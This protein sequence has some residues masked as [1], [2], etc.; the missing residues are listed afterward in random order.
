MPGSWTRIGLGIVL[1]WMAAVGAA[2]QPHARPLERH[3]GSGDSCYERVYSSEHLE[4]HKTQSVT[5]IRF[6]HFPTTFGTYD[7]NNRI[8]FDP[9][10]AEVYF[11][12]SARFRGSG[13]SFTNSG[14]CTPRGQDYRCQIECDGGGFV[15]KDKSSGSILLINKSGFAVSGCDAEAHRWLDPEPDDKVFRLDRVAAEACAPPVQ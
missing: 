13:K 14:I 6:D 7:E 11:T 15:L 8:A 12:V 10:N 9:G 3:F 4:K 5:S 1:V 2:T